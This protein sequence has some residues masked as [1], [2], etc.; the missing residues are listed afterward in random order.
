MA[1]AVNIQM[2]PSEKRGVF[3]KLILCLTT[4]NGKVHSINTLFDFEP[5]WLFT[6]DNKSEAYDFFILSTLIYNIDRLINRE[7]FSNEG[8]TREIKV[9]NI[10]VVNLDKFEKCKNQITSAINFLTGD[11]WDLN[12]AYTEP[13]I[14]NKKKKSEFCVDQHTFNKVCLFSGGLDSLIGFI[15]LMAENPNNKVLLISHK[16]LG[17][18]RKDQDG[19]IDKL[20]E[21]RY[22]TGRYKLLQSNIGMGRK[23]A[24]NEKASSETTF[25][26][27]SLLFIGMG[28]YIANNISQTTP[29]V[30]P[31]NGTIS[32]NLPLD[33]SRRSACS[34]RTTHPNF[35]NSIQSIINN[36]GMQNKI[37]TPYSFATKG[38]MIRDC[39]DKEL[40]SNLIDLSCSCAKRGHNQYWDA[41]PDAI[42]DNKIRH[43]GMCLPCLYRRVSLFFCGLDEDNIEHKYGTD[44]FNGKKYRIKDVTQKSSR[45]FRA[46]L[47]FVN[48]NK[49]RND[50]EKELVICG[51]KDI[52]NI[53]FYSALILRNVDQIKTWIMC[54]G[55]DEI[56]RMAG[57]L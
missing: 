45:D 50:I 5:L 13:H 53:H 38:E 33:P 32:L 51:V 55:S 10:P 35:I 54:K 41:L 9:N 15:D 39:K 31:E 30:V 3:H 40:L 36:L 7:Q 17:K 46:L 52:E 47:H 19:V 11:N 24:D 2:I 27:R 49:T 8:W 23:W 57:L 29:L 48:Q 43:C 21:M 34:T 44:V 16:G 14:Y 26:S 28:I 6:E 18:E 56:K 37:I 25:R 20:S 22:Y 4:D 42:R 1:V 12:F